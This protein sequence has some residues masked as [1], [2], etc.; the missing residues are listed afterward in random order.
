MKD[1]KNKTISG[2]IWRISERV[3]AQFVSLIVSIILAR[4]L[5]PDEYGVIALVMVFIAILNSFVTNGLGTS[6]V[7]KKDSDDLD[8]STIFIAGLFL[9]FILYIILFIAS[10]FIGLWFSNIE[11]VLVLRVMGIK[12]PISSIS[13]IQQAYVSK[14]MEYKKFF[15]STLIGT[16][17]SGILGIIAAML[18]FGVWALIIQYLSN[19]IIDTIVLFLTI[20]W[21]P[22]LRFSIERF[23]KLFTYGYKVML[24]GVI[25]TIF[26]QLKSFIIGLKYTQADLAYYNRGEQFPSLICNNV[27]VS[28]E[29]VLF[30]TISHLQDDKKVVKDA[31]RR[32]ISCACYI[33]MP[34]MLGLAVISK[35]LVIIILTEKWLPCVPFLIIVCIQQGFGIVS[36]IHLQSIKAIGRSD[37]LEIVKKPLFLIFILV[38]MFYGPLAIVFANCLYGFVALAIN[39]GPN[40]KIL[41]YTI[42]EQINDVLPSILISLVMVAICYLIGLI[43]FNI[44][45]KLGLQVVVGISIYLFLS[46]AFKIRTL[47]YIIDFLR[48][49]L[50]KFYHTLIRLFFGLNIF[51]VKYNKIIFDNFNGNGYGGN[52]KYIA[53]EIINQKLPYDMVWLVNQSYND[54]PPT[55]RV[56]RKGSLKSFYELA[57]SKIWIDN[58]RNSKIVKKKKNQFYIQTW[59]AGVGLKAVEKDAEKNL[60]KSYVEEAK[61]DGEILDIILTNNKFQEEYMR[62]FFWIQGKIMNIGTPRCDILYNNPENIDDKVYNYFKVDKK[63]ALA[64]YA[65]TFRN[66]NDFSVFCFNYEKCCKFLE[67]RFKKKFIMLIRLH[68]NIINFKDYI[69]YNQIIRN[70]TDYPDV[71]ELIASSM[72]VITDYSSIGF[73]ASMVYKPTFIYAKDLEKYKKEERKIIYE[74]DKIPMDVCTTE[75]ELL[76]C[77]KSFDEEKY[78]KKCKCFYSNIG[79][80][81]T[82]HAAKDVVKI[83]RDK[84]E[85][86]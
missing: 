18:G 81:N 80:N 64:L 42:K 20:K 83:I 86:E 17:V 59:H 33:I 14:R 43:N 76:S 22:R 32:I 78:L 12:L 25:G 70:A 73:E 79:I 50:S 69:D 74:F 55:I 48:P 40:R 39:A 10:P 31:L 26:D 66:S 58:V 29:S 27:N 35:S 28:L 84:M 21:R 75:R 34:F 60:S 82:D 11:I 6:L 46:I 4:I 53:E 36:T 49:Y 61:H 57:T 19:S 8:F 52:P 54:F 1:I 16:I 15:Y 68:P 23:K 2:I 41:K 7:Q 56:V 24:T 9:S 37:K 62:K 44:Y 5:L 3:L 65:P 85:G 45:V 13:S 51:K 71:Q 38:G 77:I 47:Y 67:Q 63:Y 30:S 72:V